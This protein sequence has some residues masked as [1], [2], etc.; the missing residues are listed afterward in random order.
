MWVQQLEDKLAMFEEM[1][2]MFADFMEVACGST[3]KPWEPW[4]TA[5]EVKPEASSDKEAEIAARLAERGLDM[6]VGNAA[7]TN[8]VDSAKTA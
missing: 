4:T 5:V 3:H 6:A 2:H 7:N 8:G 1:Y